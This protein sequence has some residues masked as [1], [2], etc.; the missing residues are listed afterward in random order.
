MEI[1]VLPSQF[2]SRLPLPLVSNRRR[3]EF[4]TVALWLRGTLTVST[5]SVGTSEAFVHV[6][7][8]RCPRGR[9]RAIC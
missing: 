5:R 4:E 8:L 9:C 7:K 2:S 1:V 6:D 3:K